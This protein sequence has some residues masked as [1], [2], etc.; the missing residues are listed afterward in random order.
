MNI[1]AQQAELNPKYG[2][3][4]LG[5]TLPSRCRQSAFSLVEMLAVIGVIGLIAATTTPMLFSTMKANRL[6]AAGEELVNRISLA[7][8]M[9]VSRNHEVELRFYHFKDPE[10]TTAGDHYRSTLIVEP[11]PD[12]EAPTA[13]AYKVLSEMS[14]LRGGI[15]IAND[16]KLSPPFAESSRDENTDTDNYVRTAEAKY[17]TVRFFPDGSCDLT[18]ITN[19]SYLTLVDARE[20]ENGNAIPNNF[21]AIQVDHYTSRVT[22]YRP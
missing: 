2:G 9:A 18:V 6:T 14:Y 20:F 1:F 10:D 4:R 16:E 3:G 8:Q 17:K 12:P 13:T 19:E 7:Q 15:V 22:P 11:A 21:F 5:H